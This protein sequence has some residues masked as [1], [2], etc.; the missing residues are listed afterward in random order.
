[1]AL[2]KSILESQQKEIDTMNEI[3]KSL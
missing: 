2:A 1:V 3:L